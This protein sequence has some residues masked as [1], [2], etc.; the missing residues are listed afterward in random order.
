VFV[1]GSRHRLSIDCM[2]SHEEI[3]AFANALAHETNY[4]VVSEK[5]DSRVALLSS[6]KKEQ[7]IQNL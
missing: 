2:P 3:L 5:R 7:K 1:G 4:P 6:G